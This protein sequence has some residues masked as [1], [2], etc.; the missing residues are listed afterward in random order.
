MILIVL[1]IKKDWGLIGLF[2]D[3][4]R[5]LIIMSENHHKVFSLERRCADWLKL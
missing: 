5:L 4:I 3:S 1:I 2:H